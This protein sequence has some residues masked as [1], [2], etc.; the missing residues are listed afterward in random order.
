MVYTFCCHSVTTDKSCH[1]ESFV[2]LPSQTQKYAFRM[3]FWS[4]NISALENLGLA[5]V[6]FVKVHLPIVEG[7]ETVQE[8]GTWDGVQNSLA[9]VKWKTGT[10]GT[11]ARI[12]FET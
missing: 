8:A 10:H 1:T 7:R 12:N 9:K 6:S 5:S 2:A 3:L 11:L 4:Y